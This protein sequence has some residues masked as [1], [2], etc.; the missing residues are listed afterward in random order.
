MSILRPKFEDRILVNSQSTDDLLN[1]VIR[2]IKDSDKQ[3]KAIAPLFKRKSNIT[4]CYLIYE[5]LRK[6]VPYQR[7]SANSQTVRTV[8]RILHD[9]HGDCK[10][11]AIFSASILK[12]LNIPFKL[13][14]ISQ[15][16]FDPE[17]KHI[18]V[19]CEDIVLDPVLKTFNNE[20]Q[21][22]H[23]YDYKLK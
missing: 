6:N 23:K 9:K 19:I 4:T 20:A 5:F 14:L 18:Y 2:A 15:D 13:R 7:E 22:K 16:H 10:H 3:A 1:G 12:A 8:A 17:P 11:Y 21:Y